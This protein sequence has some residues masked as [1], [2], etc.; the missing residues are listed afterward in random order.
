MMIS[1]DF[2]TVVIQKVC[3]RVCGIIGIA[4]SQY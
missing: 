3:V 4:A 1:V 2:V